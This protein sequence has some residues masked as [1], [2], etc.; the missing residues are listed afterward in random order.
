MS[1]TCLFETASRWSLV[2]LYGNSFGVTDQCWV[3]NI[4]RWRGQLGLPALSEEELSKQVHSLDMPGGQASLVDMTGTDKSGK[5][6]RMV[7]VILPQTEQ[8]WFYK[9]M[10]DP[11]I[12]EQQKDA[13]TKF[14]QSAKFSNAP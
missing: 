6:A 3:S 11:Q 1:F 7:G 14:I 10:G 2:P 12:V 8:T 4:T 13:F 5:A 9:L